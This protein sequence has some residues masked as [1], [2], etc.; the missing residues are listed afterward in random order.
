METNKQKDAKA[1]IAMKEELDDY[2]KALYRIE[3]AYAPNMGGEEAL[4]G[5]EI[6]SQIAKDALGLH[7]KKCCGCHKAKDDVMWRI[8]P[9]TLEINDRKEFN[10]W[11]DDCLQQR[12]EDI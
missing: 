12:A 10:Y 7:A 8:D 2:R 4:L 11:C 9:F 3:R 5:V 6:V 1:V